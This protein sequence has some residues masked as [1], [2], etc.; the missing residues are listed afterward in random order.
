MRVGARVEVGAKRRNSKRD[1]RLHSGCK[2]HWVAWPGLGKW[3]VL[4]GC[5]SD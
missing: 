3:S 1:L 2:T 4:I 5:S